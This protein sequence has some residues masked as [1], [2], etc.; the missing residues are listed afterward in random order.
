MNMKVLEGMRVDQ[1]GIV[2]EDV[3]KAIEGYRTIIGSDNFKTFEYPGKAKKGKIYYKGKSADFSIK[4]GFADVGGVEIELIQPLTGMSIYKDFLRKNG[5][6]IH[7][8][9]ISLP[10]EEF[11]R[12]CTHL[13]KEGIEILSEGPGVRSTSRWMVFNTREILGA[14]IEIK[15]V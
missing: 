11:D 9:R 12:L 8:Y 1:I 13:M 2:V 7:H 5:S 4:V 6:G 10:E 3:E 14:D 15:R